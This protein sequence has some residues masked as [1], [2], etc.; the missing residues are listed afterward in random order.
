MRREVVEKARRPGKDKSAAA[1]VHIGRIGEIEMPLGPCHGNIKQ[2]PFFFE[3][4]VARRGI[5]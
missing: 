1:L 2:A 4:I 3:V 5:D